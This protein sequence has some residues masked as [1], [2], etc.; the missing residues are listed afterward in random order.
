MWPNTLEA[1]RKKKE[2]FIKDRDD[3]AEN[4]RQE[5]DAEVGKS[6]DIYCFALGSFST[7]VLRCFLFLASF[8]THF[9]NL[10]SNSQKRFFLVSN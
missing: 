4:R 9:L 3:A 8:V 2:T 6:Y 7:S 10:Y 1:T 5:I